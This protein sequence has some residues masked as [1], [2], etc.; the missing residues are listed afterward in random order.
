MKHS[1]IAPSSAAIWGKPDGCTGYVAMSAAYPETEESEA[2]KNGTAS[3]ELGEILIRMGQTAGSDKITDSIRTDIVSKMSSDGVMFTDEMFNAAWEYADDVLYEL[4]TRRGARLEVEHRVTCPSI[5]TESFG[6][7]DAFMHD[8]F[9]QELIVWDYKYGM[10]TVEAFENWQC[11][12]YVAGLLDY[13]QCEEQHITVR[14]RIVQPRAFHK[15]GTIREWVIKASDLRVHINTL[16]N[17]AHRALGPDAGTL[18]GDHCKHCEARHAC[19]VALTAGM[20]LYEIAGKPLTVELDPNAMGIQLSVVKRAIRQLQYLE[21]AY[22]EQVKSML[23]GGKA[24]RGWYTMPKFGRVKWNKPYDEIVAMGDMM[25]KDLRK[26]PVAITPAQAI[27]LGVD[28]TLIAAY[29]EK[30]N[31]GLELTETSTNKSREVFSK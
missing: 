26:D 27:K 13:L 1:I 3:H 7:V 29:S 19:D 8:T 18:T 30:P 28:K 12:N 16:H 6:T 11:I 22:E 2:S 5:H 20:K 14:I 31:N 17:N 23:R 4:H 25:G 9:K 15:E 10:G 24:V 21:S